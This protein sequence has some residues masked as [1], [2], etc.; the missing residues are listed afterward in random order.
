[1]VLSCSDRSMLKNY[2]DCLI[3]TQIFPIWARL[4]VHA[5]N[6]HVGERTMWAHVVSA[7]AIHAASQSATDSRSEANP[8]SIYQCIEI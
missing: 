4:R 6:K 8:L 7:R 3:T 5:S 2:A 1:M